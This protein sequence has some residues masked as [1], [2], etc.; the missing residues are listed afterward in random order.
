MN[1]IEAA[2]KII[3]KRLRWIR[4]SDFVDTSNRLTD[5]ERLE[6]MSFRVALFSMNDSIPD[7]PNKWIFPE[8]PEWL[9]PHLNL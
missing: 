1:K 3:T 7:E 6:G 4:N 5:E 9:L 8:A 2:Q